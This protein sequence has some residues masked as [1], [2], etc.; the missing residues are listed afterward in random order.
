MSEQRYEGRV[1]LV[2]GAGSGIG[3][4]VAVRL[5]TEGAYVVGC[6]V[7]ADGLAETEKQIVDAGRTA[8]TV[9]GDVSVQADVER[10]VA[11]LPDGRIDLLANVAGIMDF[12]LPVTEVD[13]ATWERVMAVNVTGPMRLSRA[14]LP[15]MRTAGGGA[16]VNVASIGGLTGAV[17]G[18]AYVTS[19]HALIGMTRSIA[20]LYAADGIRA[21]AICPGGVETN[22]GR[23][24]VPK[25]PWAYER[26][27]TSF[28]RSTRTAQPD[29]IAT[30]VSWLGSAEA[31]NVNGA[32]VTSDGGFT[33]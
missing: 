2:T 6:D 22:I 3:Q 31:V 4:A 1:A 8:V 24:A 29:E 9:I 16:I 25:V 7:D 28:A 20:V 26:L 12:F 5:A 14:V 32:V 15:L 19:K 13:D 33:A 23:T 30:L 27:S 10:I 21:T 18:T 17:A 11:A